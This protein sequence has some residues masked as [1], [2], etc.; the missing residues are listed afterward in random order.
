MHTTPWQRRLVIGIFAAGLVVATTAPSEAAA[1]LASFGRCLKSKGATF[2]GT[3]WCPHCDA[4]RDTLG[5]AMDYVKYV[6]CSV[7]GARGETTAAC[8]KAD[9]DGYPTWTFADGSREGGAQS[10]RNLATKTGCTLPRDA[11]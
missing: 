1:T 4:Q 8:K 9:V 5:D 2:Y 3:S 11:D 6:E 7:E 10:L